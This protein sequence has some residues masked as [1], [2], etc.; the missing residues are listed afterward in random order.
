MFE[1]AH[2]L[3]PSGLVREPRPSVGYQFHHRPEIHDNLAIS[4]PGFAWA[5]RAGWLKR[6]GLYESMVT[7]GGDSMML[8]GFTDCDLHMVRLT[9]AAWRRHVCAWC[10][11]VYAD[12][13]SALG[14]VPGTILHL[15][16]G[17]KKNRR[18]VE[19]W[20][21]LTDR[22]FDP[23]TDLI[24]APNGLLQWSDHARSHKAEMVR[25]V[26]HYFSE[27]HE[28]DYEKNEPSPPH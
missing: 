20:R 21:Y 10:R 11:A 7:G 17:E 9:N 28:D 12:T 4:H 2:T 8:P 26:Q 23:D 27:R 13:Q 15:Y 24:D 14:Y 1:S 19:R 3:T 5:A 6:H 18:Y 25:L 16:H 22:D